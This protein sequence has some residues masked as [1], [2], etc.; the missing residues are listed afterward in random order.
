M[1][2]AAGILIE[3]LPV[4][5]GADVALLVELPV[6]LVALPVGA[7]DPSGSLDVSLGFSNTT[8]G[9]ALRSLVELIMGTELCF[10]AEDGC[11]CC[12]VLAVDV[13][14]AV[15]V[16]AALVFTCFVTLAELGVVTFVDSAASSGCGCNRKH[17]S[18][19][20]SAQSLRLPAMLTHLEKHTSVPHARHTKTLSGTMT[21]Q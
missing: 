7:R 18:A 16:K 3:T 11:A 5:L 20:S 12:W 4:G 9:F 8:T 17:A 14:E 6:A 19:S 21:R 10:V 13:M 1:S 15:V 2:A